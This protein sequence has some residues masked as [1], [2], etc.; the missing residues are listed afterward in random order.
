MKYGKLPMA[1]SAAAMGILILDSRAAIGYAAEGIDMCIRTVIPSLLPFCVVGMVLTRQLQSARF[2]RP[3]GRM[4]GLRPGTESILLAGFLG[5]YPVGAQNTANA[6]RAGIL[7]EQ[8]A[9]RMLCFCSQPGPA[10]L[11]GILGDM[12]SL[13]QCWLLW[14]IILLGAWLVSRL[15]PGRDVVSGHTMHPI[16]G[17]PPVIK[18]AVAAMA[19]ICGWIIL[20]RIVIGFLARWFLWILPNPV[21]CA[22]SGMLELTNGCLALR[23]IANPQ[24]RFI[25]AAGMLSFGGICV[26]LQTHS[27]IQGLSIRSY[28][29]GKLLQAM[30]CILLAAGVCGYIWPSAALIAG[31]TLILAGK[32]RKNSSIPVPVGV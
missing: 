31:L 28:V 23:S 2:L 5:G 7:S 6:W 29:T 8:E 3:V 11:F 25:L 26:T 30:I 15:F 14:G 4:F 20:I 12:F 13:K 18:S 27:L 21:S 16:S 9:D 24:L 32:S 22:L 10:F 19:N 17:H 1:F